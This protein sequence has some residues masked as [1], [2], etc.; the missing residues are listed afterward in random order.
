M[1]QRKR[2]ILQ[3]VIDDYILSAEPVGSRTI[4]RQHDLGVSSATIRNEMA[5]L[6]NM[7]YLEHLH[8]SSG[9]IPSAKGYRLYVNDL[10]P[11][12][13]MTDKEKALID[14]WYRARVKSMEGVF[15]ETTKIISRVTKNMSLVLAPQFS[16]ARFKELRFMELDGE[17]VVAILLTDTGFVEN[18]VVRMPPG[19]EFKDFTRMA[20]V[21]NRCLAGERLQTIR[22]KLYRRIRDEM[23]D[24]SLYNAAMELIHSALGEEK[25]ERL[26][27]GGTRQMLEQPEFQDVERVRGILT[28]LEEEQFVKGILHTDEGG[29][30]TVTIGQENEVKGLEDVSVI[31]ATYRLDGELLGTIAV[32]GPTRMEYGRAM[33]LIEYLHTSLR[34][35]VGRYSL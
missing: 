26:Y 7:G 30:L 20:E 35:I 14:H 25:K 28:M 5:N 10:L 19:S 15:Q 6:E 27:L 18:R 16:Q 3:A 31:R 21:I 11:R 13:P 32:L 12:E 4:A 34:A 17:R 9:R 1:N 2:R 33:S 24:E 8:T 23:M 22:P 29:D